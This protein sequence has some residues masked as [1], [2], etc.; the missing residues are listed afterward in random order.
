[1]NKILKTGLWLQVPNAIVI[2]FII[3][4]VIALSIDW[5]AIINNIIWIA[6]ITI[7]SLINIFSAIFIIVGLFLKEEKR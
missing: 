2:T 5:I 6:A 4:L 1:M 3:A 7:Y